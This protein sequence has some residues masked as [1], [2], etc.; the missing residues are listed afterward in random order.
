MNWKTFHKR[1]RQ[2]GLVLVGMIVLF[3]GACSGEVNWTKYKGTKIKIMSWAR[4]FTDVAISLIPEFE[5]KT[6][7]KVDWIV[8]DAWELRSKIVREFSIGMASMDAFFFHPSQRTAFL[9]AGD[10][11][12]DQMKYIKDPSLTPADWDFD[13]FLPAARLANQD[14]DPNAAYSLPFVSQPAGM[15]YRNDLFEKYGIARPKTFE[16]TELAAQKL[17]LDLNG[18]GTTDIYGWLARGPGSQSMTRIGGFIFAYG[19]AWWTHDRKSAID[20]PET[21]RGIREYCKL[22]RT[23][24]PPNP[25]ELGFIEGARLFAQGKAAM[26]CE[27]GEHVA[28]FEDPTR[29]KVVGKVGMGPYPAG[30][31]GRVAAPEI[32]L[33]GIPKYSKNKEATWLFLQWLGNK[34]NAKRILA[35]GGAVVRRSAWEDPEVKVLNKEWA[36][37]CKLSLEVGS[38]HFIMFNCIPLQ[39]VRDLWGEVVDRG[40]EGKPIEEFA[41]EIA[42]KINK[43]I[44]KTEAGKHIYMNP[45]YVYMPYTLWR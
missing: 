6:G 9:S 27:A 4:P 26:Y 24:G 35:G 31:A 32:V 21:L 13:D 2:C 25:L 30:P 45:R 17:T 42:K 33:M 7:I 10:H 5:A 38:E 44:E 40:M 8:M 20:K 36:D 1:L 28:L 39:E 12:V 16:E 14:F 41:H 23:Y 29:S 22:M 15:W 37:Y 3:T 43:L 34:K 19:G 18:D 11:I